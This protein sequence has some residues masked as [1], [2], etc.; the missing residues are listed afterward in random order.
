[1][2]SHQYD[3][4]HY[5]DEIDGLVQERRNSIANALE[6]CLSC[7]NPLRWPHDHLDYLFNW[8]IP[9]PRNAA[10]FLLKWGIVISFC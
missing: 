4:S 8:N 10:F 7:T 6:L 1:M 9:A 2:L 3:D 5:T